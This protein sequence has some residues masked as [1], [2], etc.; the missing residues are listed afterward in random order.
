MTAIAFSLLRKKLG[1]IIEHVH[2]AE[3]PIL[4]TRADGK[5]V[6]I[7]PESWASRNDSVYLLDNPTNA[8]VLRQSL[9]QF[10]RGETMPLTD[11]Q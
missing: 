2:D 3:E 11:L 5:N 1:E 6:L 9:E 7:V 4:V 8:A 10:E